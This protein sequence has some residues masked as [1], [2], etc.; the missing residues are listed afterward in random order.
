MRLEDIFDEY[1]G[2]PPSEDA[3]REQVLIARLFYMG[4]YHGDSALVQIGDDLVGYQEGAQP[5]SELA[6]MP[7]EIIW[8]GATVIAVSAIF[9]DR[10]KTI[11]QE[12]M[13]AKIATKTV[14]NFAVLVLY[15]VAIQQEWGWQYHALNLAWAVLA[16]WDTFQLVKTL[17][18]AAKGSVEALNDIANTARGALSK[19]A[20]I[21]F[22]VG[23]AVSWGLFFWQMAQSGVPFGSMAYNFAI[24]HQIATTIASAIL[25][26]IVAIPV[27]G[28]IISVIINLF[29][30]IVYFICDLT[31]SENPVCRGIQ[32]YLADAI[33]SGIYSGDI[34]ITLGSEARLRITAFDQ[35]FRDPALGVSVGNA[36]VSDV[37]F[38]TRF[39]LINSDEASGWGI[40]YY[41]WQYNDDTTRSSTF[42]YSFK[43]T[44][45]D[46]SA[47]GAGGDG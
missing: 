35:K 1:E 24:A 6:E 16:A 3:R 29:D 46:E 40:I 43:S 2:A 28:W 12:G 27:V 42:R 7:P 22:I 17:W 38:R 33:T 14:I 39:R 8:E 25:I 37:D 18:G 20:W 11:A 26:L 15:Y 47:A 34:M 31:E 10:V 21:G 36:I 23:T 9:S 5:D 30:C 44:P 13:S 32:G 4:L 19:A 41:W 45:G